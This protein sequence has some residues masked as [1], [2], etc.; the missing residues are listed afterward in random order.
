MAKSITNALIGILVKQ[1]KL[2]VDLLL[3]FDEWKDDDRKNITIDQLL[4]ANS[5]LNWEESYT[6]PKQRYEHAI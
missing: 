2:K 6:G 5:G 3:G 1:G 4:H